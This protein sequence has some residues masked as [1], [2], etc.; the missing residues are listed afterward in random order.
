MMLGGVRDERRFED[1]QV[2]T[3]FQS[4]SPEPPKDEHPAGK[5]GSDLRWAVAGV[6]VGPEQSPEAV[7]TKLSIGSW[8]FVVCGWSNPRRISIPAEPGALVLEPLGA[9]CPCPF[10]S[11]VLPH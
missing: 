2:L 4:T 5:S 6:S 8:N 7:K 1:W 10:S 9:A 3:S 11:A